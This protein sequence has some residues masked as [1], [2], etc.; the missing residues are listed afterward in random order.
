MLRRLLEK[1]EESV[2]IRVI[3]ARK[4]AV[5]TERNGCLQPAEGNPLIPNGRSHKAQTSATIRAMAFHDRPDRK[6]VV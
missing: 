3:S 4:A 6:S 1:N 5:T 2:D